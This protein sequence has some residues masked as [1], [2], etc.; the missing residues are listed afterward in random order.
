MNTSIFICLLGRPNV[1][2]LVRNSVN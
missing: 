2:T 1:Y